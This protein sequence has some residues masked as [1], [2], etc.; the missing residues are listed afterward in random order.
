[1]EIFVAGVFTLLS[2]AAGLIVFYL[3]HKAVPEDGVQ[4][5]NDKKQNTPRRDILAANIS[6]A[7]K[8]VSWK[9]W[10]LLAVSSVLIG[11]AAYRL[12]SMELRLMISGRLLITALLLLPAMFIDWHARRIPNA[13][14]LTMLVTGL[15]FLV[16]EFFTEREM[17]AG[18]AI[19]YIAGLLG[20]LVLFYLLARITKDGIGM[21]DV[22]LIA[23]EGWMVGV[24]MA[25]AAT[26]FSLLLCSVTAV[27]LLL[28]KKKKANDQVPFG[29]F[30]FFGY[31][32]A[33]LFCNI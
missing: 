10:V 11:A 5:E 16:L 33:I 7:L 2:I 22:K 6:V 20:C 3:I 30:I 14:I 18:Q 24:V 32:I 9:E 25:V 4:L 15:V 26:I 27:C 8:S 13:L 19:S 29:P 17:F 31:I 21:G 23:A 1:M 12:Q 28:C